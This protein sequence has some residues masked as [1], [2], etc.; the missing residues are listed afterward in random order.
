[1][2]T[3]NTVRCW[4]N[5]DY[6]QLD[7]VTGATN[8]VAVAAG[9]IH[10]CALLADHTV[11]CW[12]VGLLGQ[13]GNGA[14]GVSYA[15]TVLG[16]TNADAIVA[17]GTHSCALLD[18]RTVRCWGNNGSGQLG[19]G[20]LVDQ[21]SP[22][23]VAGLSDVTAISAGYSHTCALLA[24]GAVECWGS[25][26]FG[27]LGDGTTVSRGTPW[28]VT[29]IPLGT[30]G[31]SGAGGTSS[32]GG[33]T[34]AG[35]TAPTGGAGGTGGSTSNAC[36]SCTSSLGICAADGTCARCVDSES[37]GCSTNANYQAVVT[38]L[39]GNAQRCAAVP[40][41]SPP[42][43]PPSSSRPYPRTSRARSLLSRFNSTQQRMRA[44]CA[45]VPIACAPRWY[46]NSLAPRR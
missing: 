32:T 28:L 34:G 7:F 35:G 22:V 36:G 9:S 25:N 30:G 19:D 27:Q 33:T 6:H 13:I 10:T 40:S 24:N 44:N 31:T 46:R 8:V 4:G 45:S 23:A 16:I 3:D 14:L 26:I 38:C 18:D 1:M 15:A 21:S 17:G 37:V 2:R 5:D 42:P 20:S 11:Q 29:G 43:L 39:C 41:C 12:G